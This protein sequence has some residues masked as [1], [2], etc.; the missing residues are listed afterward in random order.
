MVCWAQQFELLTDYAYRLVRRRNWNAAIDVEQA[1]NH[2]L[3]QWLEYE[4][5][6]NARATLAEQGIA[7][8]PPL[9]KRMVKYRLLDKVRAEAIYPIS[10]CEAEWLHRI[11]APAEQH[12]DIDSDGS[13]ETNQPGDGDQRSSA[14][15]ERL[16]VYMSRR[17]P[18]TRDMLYM[19]LA[20]N[21]PTA[22]VAEKLSVSDNAVNCAVHRLSTF[23][24]NG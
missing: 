19:R 1:C 4:G 17:T 11:A 3:Q 12:S 7:D 9:L 5:E 13:D 22:E 14:M 16:A 2:A 23:M 10:P 24:N 8:P 21:M 6:Q 20:A 18:R 15:R